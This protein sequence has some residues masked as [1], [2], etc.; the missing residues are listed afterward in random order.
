MRYT[1]RA[2]VERGQWHVAIYPDGVESDGRVF[3]GTRK[4][5]EAQARSMI[6]KWLDKRSANSP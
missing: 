6:T 3:L 4:E 1:I 5:A 2:R